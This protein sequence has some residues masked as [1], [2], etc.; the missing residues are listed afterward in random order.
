[1]E[2]TKI[3]AQAKAEVNFTIKFTLTQS[4]AAALEAIA[5]YGHEPFLKV[6][7]EHMGKSYL[8]PHEVGMKNLFARIKETLPREISKIDAARE[9]INEALSKFNP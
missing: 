2:N 1:M 6:F 5:G 4:E 7:Y 3:V 8:Q 9:A